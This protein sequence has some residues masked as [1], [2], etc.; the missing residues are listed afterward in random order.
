[1]I[2]HFPV[3]SITIGVLVYIQYFGMST[4]VNYCILDLKTDNKKIWF[5]MM[6]CA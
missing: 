3:A 6:I 1:M 2:S 4:S 5:M